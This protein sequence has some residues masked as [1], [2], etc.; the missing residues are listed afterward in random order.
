MYTSIYIYRIKKENLQEFLAIEREVSKVYIEHGAVFND[1]YRAS[2]L[3]A[4]YGCVAFIDAMDVDE[5]K[6][7]LVG[8][9]A[10]G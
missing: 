9:S 7:I 2:D 10:A 4:Q 1:I 8:P 6:E 3:T 5:D